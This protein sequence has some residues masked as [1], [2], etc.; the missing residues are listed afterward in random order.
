MQL[1]P[2]PRTWPDRWRDDYGERVTHMCFDAGMTWE[3]A[4]IAAEAD[5]RKQAE[6]DA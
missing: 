3:R 5:V 1:G 2:D 6:G 4:Q